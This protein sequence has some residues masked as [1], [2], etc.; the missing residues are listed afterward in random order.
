MHATHIV[1]ILISLLYAGL[2]FFVLSRSPANV[3]N[4]RF[5]IVANTFCVWASLIFFTLQT[6]DPVLA[7][8]R[9]RLVFCAATFIPSTLFFFTSVFPDKRES[10][11]NQYLSIL[12]FF[13]SIILSFF[14]SLI[15]N[16]VSFEKHLP[17]P[18]YGPLFTV[19]CFYFVACSAYSVYILYKKSMYHY[20]IKKLQIQYFYFGVAVSLFLGTVTNFILPVINIWHAESFVPLITTPIPITVAYAIVK[21]HLMDITVIIRRSTVYT[22]LSIVL[23]IIYFTVGLIMSSILPVSEYKETI[24]NMVSAIVMVL[25]FIPARESIQHLVEK[26]LFHTKYSHPKILSAS[27]IMFSSIHDLDGLL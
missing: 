1:N 24:T 18:N 27:T 15:V 2:G 26:T 6:T 19:F 17:H 25:T 14:S 7:T 5:C 20:G 23:S 22:A 10:F 8:F 21:Y 11:I 3:I 12:F 4:K 9:L 13:I 16:S